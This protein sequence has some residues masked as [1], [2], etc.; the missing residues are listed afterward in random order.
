MQADISLPWSH[1]FYYA[2]CRVLV[3]LSSVYSHAIWPNRSN[4]VYT[5]IMTAMSSFIFYKKKKKKKKKTKN[6][7][8]CYLLLFRISRLKFILLTLEPL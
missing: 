6:R 2:F 8:K 3:Q 4:A 7:F 5:L 1:K